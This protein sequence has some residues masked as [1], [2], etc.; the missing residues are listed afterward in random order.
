VRPSENVEARA[1]RSGLD[2]AEFVLRG[3]RSHLFL[4]LSG[5]GLLKA[6]SGENRL[7]APSFLWLPHG[8]PGA[9]RLEAGTRGATLS[10]PDIMLGRAI[11]AGPVGSHIRSVIGHPI[12]GRRL[13]AAPSGRM[14]ELAATVER[15]LFENG[16]AADAVVQSCLTLLLIE[17]WR[18]SRPEPGASA[19]MPRNIVHSFLFLVDLHLKD[20][21]SV[22]RYA[23]QL[24]V[25]R[26][27]LN[28]AVKRATGRTPLSHI[29]R[30]LMAEAREMLGEPGFQ[31]AEVA[32][33]LGFDD[34]AY[35]NRF[36]QRHAGMP[37]GRY[38]RERLADRTAPETSFAAWP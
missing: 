15:E 36:F 27:R 3:G 20:H 34:A 7:A 19:A 33:R 10:I 21:W 6:G 37:P 28:S 35:F 11:P 30:R 13:D 5:N 12:I 31:V 29:H 32:Y 22:G 24:G 1:I 16:P 14:T 25:S 26:E 2:I 18:T 38:R 9:L 17:I 8:Q 23:E 4:L